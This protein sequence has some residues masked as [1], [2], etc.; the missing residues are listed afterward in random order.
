MTERRIA[1]LFA[2]QGTE[3]P[4]MGLDLAE[5]VP[6]A[7]ALLRRAG[8]VAR[9]DALRL[10]ATGGAAFRRTSVIQPLIAAVGLGAAAAL[11]RAGIEPAMVG[12]HSLGELAAW[13]TAG[14]MSP[15]LAVELAGVRGRLMER[16]AALHPGGML[17]LSG[18]DQRRV[19]EAVAHGQRC[20]AAVLAAHNAPD[21]W[22]VSGE[23]SALAAIAAGHPSTRL[24]VG[25]AWHSPAMAGAVAELAEAM[26]AVRPA[27]PSIPWIV[28]RTGAIATGAEDPAELVA[29]QLVR[30]V[31]WVRTMAALVHERITHVV[32]LGPSKLMRSLVRKNIGDRARLVSVERFDDV[33]RALRELD[34]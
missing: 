14:A 34:R 21:D 20:G 7:A 23:E 27:R 5:R 16:E 18:C 24:P 30:P 15:E 9:V 8:E 28:N 12:G 22:T 1:F 31:Q 17:A 25:G 4:R 32:T 10:L 2:G 6:T 19:A 29:G 3:A 26:R 13:S 33:E 11:A